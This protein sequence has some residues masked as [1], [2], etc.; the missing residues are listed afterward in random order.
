[1]NKLVALTLITGTLVLGMNSFSASAADVKGSVD[2]SVKV[3][4]VIQKNAGIANKNVAHLGSVSG[5]ARIGGDF[6]S[7]VA[8]G[9]IIQKNTGIANKN[10]VSLGSVTH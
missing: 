8:V 2:T 6:K 1:M 10:S 3:G 9:A 4:A 5:K 7:R